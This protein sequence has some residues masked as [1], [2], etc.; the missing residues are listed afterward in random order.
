MAVYCLNGHPC[1]PCTWCVSLAQKKNTKCCHCRES[2]SQGFQWLVSPLASKHPFNL[3][4]LIS[5]CTKKFRERKEGNQG[6]FLAL[7]SQLSSDL[8]LELSIFTSIASLKKKSNNASC[9]SGCKE[10]CEKYCVGY[11]FLHEKKFFLSVWSLLLIQQC[12]FGGT[13]SV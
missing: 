1:R 4:L 6:V 13:Y 2:E 5:V 11:K 8:P 9:N 12:H 7:S 10:L 3:S